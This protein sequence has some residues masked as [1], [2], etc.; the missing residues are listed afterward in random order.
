LEVLNVKCGHSVVG[1]LALPIFD[2]SSPFG[3]WYGLPGDCSRPDLNRQVS[4]TS[5]L[6]VSGW[7][8]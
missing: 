3:L 8:E 2:F 5:L 4:A 7:S 6:K 1:E